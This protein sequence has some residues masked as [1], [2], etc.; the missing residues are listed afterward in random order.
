MAVD[1]GASAVDGAAGKVAPAH[2]GHNAKPPMSAKH[3]LRQGFR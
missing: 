3:A 1:A 2:G